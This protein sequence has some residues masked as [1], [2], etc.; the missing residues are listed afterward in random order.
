M[1]RLY[2]HIL[3]TV[4]ISSNFAWSQN[5]FFLT[6]IE[7]AYFFHTVRKSPILDRAFGEYVNYTGPEVLLPN[8]EVNYD[9]IE[10]LI[11]N[12][13]SLVNIYTSEIS[14]VPK[15]LLAEAANKQA[16][17][18]LNKTLNAYRN[19]TLEKEG[20]EDRFDHFYA[21]L[22]DHLPALALEKEGDNVLVNEKV[23]KVIHPNLSFSDKAAMLKNFKRSSDEVKIKVFTAIN[24]TINKWIEERSFVLFQQYGGEADIFVNVLT[25]AG[26]G[27]STSGLFEERDKDDQGRWNKGLPKAVGL[28]PYEPILVSK[29]DKKKIEPQRYTETVLETVGGNKLTNIHL[30][31]WGYNSEK[32]TT[33]VLEK[34]GYSYPLFGSTESRFLSP[35]SAFAGDGTYYTLIDR[36][37]A[38]I[39][40]FESKISGKKGYNYWIDYHKERKDDKRLEIEKLEKE[41]SDLRLSPIRT[42]NKKYKTKS[43]KRQRK[44]RQE[45]LVAYHE[46]L[47]A[48]RRKIEEYEEKREMVLHEIQIRNQQLNHMLDLIGRKWMPFTERDGF[49]LFEDS[50]TFDIRTQEFQFPAS[51]KPEQFEV[52]LIAI[53]YS[54]VSEQADEVML[55]IN[56][57]DAT[58]D[59]TAAV[60][61]VLEDVFS[62]DKYTFEKKL[63]SENDSLSLLQF[64]T[65]VKEKEIRVTARGNGVGIWNGY[66]TIKDPKQKEQ[67]TYRADNMQNDQ[68]NK[69]LRVS[70]IIVKVEDNVSIAVDSFTDPVS[71]KFKAKVEDV[72]EKQLKYGLSGNQLLSAYR[73]AFILEKFR[74]ELN[75]LAGKLL[76]RTD[77]K[78]VIDNLNK[79]IGKA[80]IY[81]GKTSFKLDDL[82]DN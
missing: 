5:N 33:V 54:H 70:S 29:K 44:K 51:E 16:I 68:A 62:S 10:Y 32:Q 65:G 77:A 69:R 41:L 17:W 27:S 9:S 49:Y 28:F 52:R 50:S 36:L 7:K 30:D 80:R 81:V 24:A 74:K 12:D 2:L 55:H 4:F 82:I 34:G 47:S 8:G 11:I 20:L 35:D 42:N 61:I 39:L 73:T 40:H 71:T 14:K 31:V 43:G 78:V 48:I 76:S 67:K 79:S 22:T 45:R 57:S 53:P 18:E 38:D 72:N 64:F 25:A 66:K 15:G 37:Q 3:L 59:Y 60:Q 26:D 46:Q 58:P 1:I 6:P 21:I 23:L 75:V 63:V 13:P 19:N 56:V